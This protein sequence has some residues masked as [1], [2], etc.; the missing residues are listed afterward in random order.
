MYFCNKIV[1]SHLP[2]KLPNGH[3]ACQAEMVS[4][5]KKGVCGTLVEGQEELTQHL[6]QAY[7]RECGVAEGRASGNGYEYCTIVFSAKLPW[8]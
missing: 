4:F 2:K 5:K 3:L 1:Q 7:E 6:K 8:S